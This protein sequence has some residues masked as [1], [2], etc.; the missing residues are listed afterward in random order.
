[1]QIKPRSQFWCQLGFVLCQIA[2]TIRLGRFLGDTTENGSTK[3]DRHGKI[4]H[5]AKRRKTK[6]ELASKIERF[7]SV[8]PSVLC[9]LGSI[10]RHKHNGHPKNAISQDSGDTRQVQKSSNSYWV[11][12][13]RAMD[14]GGC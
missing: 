9:Q 4:V 7:P 6:N 1:M 12:H 14:S 5:C 8:V 13:D 2:R 3:R 11:K 10:F